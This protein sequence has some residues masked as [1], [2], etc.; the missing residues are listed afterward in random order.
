MRVEPRARGT[1][2]LAARVNRMLLI[3]AERHEQEM[4]LIRRRDGLWRPTEEKS[5][6][7]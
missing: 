4:D 5:E 7:F 2:D 6:T 3:T 1:A